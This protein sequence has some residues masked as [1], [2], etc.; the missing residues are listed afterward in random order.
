MKRDDQR[1]TA[2]LKKQSPKA[3]PLA[4]KL[5]SPYVYTIVRNIIGQAL[6]EQDIEEAAADCFV[7]L[8]RLAPGLKEGAPLSPYLAACA[9][10][11]AIN[12]LRT[13]SKD[14]GREELFEDISSGES[15]EENAEASY[16]LSEII[17][18][19]DTLKSE[20]REL[21]IRYY[22]YG[23]RLSDICKVIGISESSG[24]SKMFRTRAKIRQHLAERGL[25]DENN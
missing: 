1:L 23:E 2:M 6:P 18:F 16:I 9:R 20:D 21:F 10:S 24:K 17:S 12:K 14:S 22:Y 15:I 7:K 4:V 25:Y 3:L 19:L 5:Y 8:W 13:A 11:C